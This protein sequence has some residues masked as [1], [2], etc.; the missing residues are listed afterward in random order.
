MIFLGALSRNRSAAGM[1]RGCGTRTR[2]RRARLV[3]MQWPGSWARYGDGGR[4]V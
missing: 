1:S 3:P 2:M 4:A